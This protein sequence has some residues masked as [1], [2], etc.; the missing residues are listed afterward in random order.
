MYRNRYNDITKMVMQNINFLLNCLSHHT[1]Y[2]ILSFRFFYVLR[3]ATWLFVCLCFDML[4]FCFVLWNGLLVYVFDMIWYDMT[5]FLFFCFS[6]CLITTGVCQTH[7]PN[8]INI[9]EKYNCKLRVKI[10]HEQWKNGVRET[11]LVF[12]Q[13]IRCRWSI[14]LNQM[15]LSKTL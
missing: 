8:M 9:I 15:S 10:I 11:F 1:W 7:A 14:L 4:C 5:C 6:V 2:S 12:A 13:W 3:F